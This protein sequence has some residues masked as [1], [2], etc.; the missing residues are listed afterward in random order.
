VTPN[1]FP[2]TTHPLRDSYNIAFPSISKTYAVKGTCPAPRAVQRRPVPIRSLRQWL[3]NRDNK[4][5]RRKEHSMSD[6]VMLAIVFGFFSL[7]VAYTIAC[8]RL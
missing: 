7:S 3:R 2:A 6:L 8:D 4:T 5:K 1:T